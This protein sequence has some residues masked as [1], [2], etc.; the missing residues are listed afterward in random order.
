MAGASHPRGHVR[1]HRR[2]KPSGGVIRVRAH[3][4]G[5]GPAGIAGVAVGALVL[6]VAPVAVAAG[7]LVGLPL[8][9]ASRWPG[10]ARAVIRALRAAA[11]GGERVVLGGRRA[12]VSSVREALARRERRRSFERSVGVPL[13][14]LARHPELMEL[15]LE[16]LA[17]QDEPD[18]LLVYVRQAESAVHRGDRRRELRARLRSIRRTLRRA[19]RR[20]RAEARYGEHFYQRAWHAPGPAWLSQDADGVWS[21]HGRPWMPP[22]LRGQSDQTTPSGLAD[23]AALAA[24][25]ALAGTADER[26]E[27]AA[28]DTLAGVFVALWAVLEHGRDPDAGPP[29]GEGPDGK[30]STRF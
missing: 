5:V 20:L 29:A 14:R 19:E 10:E 13:E 16:S 3:R 8:W 30:L 22:K 25:A 24:L 21:R 2:R 28:R 6:G 18:G 26:V 15:A 11:V 12:G 23:A 9:A 27:P 1:A 4:R 7:L 17:A